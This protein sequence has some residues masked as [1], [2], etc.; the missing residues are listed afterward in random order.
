LAEKPSFRKSFEKQRCMVVADGFYEWKQT[1]NGK[2][3]F[4]FRLKARKPFGMA[5]LYDSWKKGKEIRSC[6][7]ITSPPNELM[8]RIHNRMPVIIPKD[9]YDAWLADDFTDQ[10]KLLVPFPSKLMEAYEVSKLINSPKNNGPECVE[11][12]KDH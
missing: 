5:G 12:V 8:S 7:I 9:K 10:H 6:T 3:P 4:F 2:V 11:R 1:S